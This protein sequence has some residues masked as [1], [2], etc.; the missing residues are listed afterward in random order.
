MQTLLSRPAPCGTGL[1]EHLRDSLAEF[2]AFVR[3]ADRNVAPARRAEQHA[4][5]LRDWTD[6]VVRGCESYPFAP[7]MVALDA[8]TALLRVHRWSVDRLQREMEVADALDILAAGPDLSRADAGWMALIAAE[9]RNWQDPESWTYAMREALVW[10]FRAWALSR[11]PRTLPPAVV[12]RLTAWAN[13]DLPPH[14]R[15]AMAAGAY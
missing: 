12:D 7:L 1:A 11:T 13:P 15:R 4:W 6:T 10:G 9:A 8:A 14:F 3:E 2:V 5:P